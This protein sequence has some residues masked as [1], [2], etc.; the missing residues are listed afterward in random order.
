MAYDKF[1]EL[2]EQFDGFISVIL[3]DWRGYRFIYDVK[4]T[5]CCKNG[6]KNCPL[7][8]LL[9]D[10][11]NGLFTAGLLPASQEDK[12]IFGPQNFL[13]CKS[14]RQYQDCYTNFLVNRCFTKEEIFSELDLMKNIRIIYSKYNWG[15]GQEVKFRR[16]VIYR[17]IDLSDPK[18]SN[19]IQQY[20]DLNLDFFSSP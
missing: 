11:K 9:K 5:T 7:Y 10:E 19:L 12:K 20:V 13:N 8:A 17:T 2:S 1:R 6:C 4:E 15:D 14:I 3:D 18:K 16:E